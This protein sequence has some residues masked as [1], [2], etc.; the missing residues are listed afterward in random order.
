MNYYNPYF[1]GSAYPRMATSGL[2]NRGLLNSLF[3]RGPT[4]FSFANL[5]TGAQKTLNVASQGINLAKQVQPMVHNARTMFKLMNE[6]KKADTP[7]E[8]NFDNK[9][10]EVL[11]VE[12]VKENKVTEEKKVLTSGPTFFQ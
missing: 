5:L 9:N 3:R 6:F 10:N 2:A 12:P 1:Y 11:N 4:N 7:K 8:N